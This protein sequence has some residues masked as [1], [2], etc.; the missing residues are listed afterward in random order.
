MLLLGY[1]HCSWQ[2][3][4]RITRLSTWRLFAVF[5]ER[6]TVWA[7]FAE[8][9]SSVI[10]YNLCAEDPNAGRSMGDCPTSYGH[11]KLQ[12]K[13]KPRVTDFNFTDICKCH[14]CVSSS[15][16]DKK[17]KWIFH[18]TCPVL[19]Q[20]N[21]RCLSQQVATGLCKKVEDVHMPKIKVTHDLC[22]NDKV[23]SR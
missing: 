17:S 13:L 2:G 4:K 11:F 7:T 21:F 6:L 23:L 5:I 10:S 20:L 16:C 14:L 9:A 8:I 3:T 18:P 12:I 15:T 1:F 22:Q 19:S